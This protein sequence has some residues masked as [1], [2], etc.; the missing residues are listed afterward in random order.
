MVPKIPKIT[1]KRLLQKVCSKTIFSRKLPS[2]IHKESTA[3]VPSLTYEIGKSSVKMPFKNFSN[4][5]KECFQ[6]WKEFFNLAYTF[7]LSIFLRCLKKIA[8]NQLYLRIFKSK[9]HL[10]SK[11]FQMEHFLSSRTLIS[12]PINFNKLPI[13]FSITKI[14]VLI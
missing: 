4:S 8:C 11:K 1:S 6:S 12:I 3:N 5:M 10:Q 7:L 13:L 14:Y 9:I 2:Y